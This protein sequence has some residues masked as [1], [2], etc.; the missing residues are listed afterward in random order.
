MNWDSV[1]L[2]S[3]W[4]VGWWIGAGI[5][6]LP[7]ASMSAE[8][9]IAVVIPARNEA[10]QI[11]TLLHSLAQQTCTIT[12]LVV[13]NDNSTDATTDVAH[14]HGARVV[15][16]TSLPEG[17]L[18]KAWACAQGVAATTAPVLVFL[19]ADT[20]LACD[21][22]ARV[23]ARVTDDSLV[24]VQPFHRAPTFGEG[25]SAAG[26]L[27]AVMG[28]GVTGLRASNDMRMAF[29]PCLAL[30]RATLE[31]LGG[32]A[33]VRG[34]VPE[35]LALAQRARTRGVRIE[36]FA[37]RS[38]LSFRMYPEGFSTMLRGFARNLA[39]GMGA[40]AW[41]RLFAIVWWMIGLVTATGALVQA[42]LPAATVSARGIALAWFLAFCA[43]WFVLTRT[44]GAFG[45]LSSWC[46]PIPLA[47][48]A[49]AFA[50]SVWLR[51]RR[52]PMRWRD[53]IVQHSGA[54][55]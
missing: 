8:R 51:L 49:V 18:G 5:R 52:A 37:G 12:E 14:A 50:R 11:A 47:V 10:H 17:W 15:H 4:G 45:W 2:A 36:T 35:D 38:E 44:V 13:V 53:R 9:A 43:Q 32:F 28:A 27:L 25:L 20:T 6:M 31:T 33:A 16:G 39:A 21:A 34:A 48:F 3:Q 55:R 19:D 23:V 7:P 30:T 24:S 42:A 46:F 1:V 41:P 29:G 54:A 22:L 26:N 40:T